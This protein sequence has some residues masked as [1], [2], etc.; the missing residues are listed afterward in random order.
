M[1]EQH[2]SKFTEIDVERINVV[3][4]DGT[5]R[6]VIANKD[7]SADPVLNGKVL[8]RRAGTYPGIIFFNDQGDECGG[9]LYGGKGE[10]GEHRACM[11][12]TF[13]QYKTDQVMGLILDDNEGRRNYGFNVWDR[14][15]LPL[16]EILE[17]IEAVNRMDD[18]PAK[19]QA[20]REL[21]P[22]YGVQR[23]FVGR[24][25]DGE[26]TVELYDRQGRPR[27]RMRIDADDI[28]RLEFLSDQGEVVYSL[29][30]RA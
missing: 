11:S 21:R 12:L 24:K 1:T 16:T 25:A 9:L 28:P 15:D 4:Q 3:D 22:F 20:R 14:P 13:D 19:E 30:P 23:I 6:M 10:L 26:A 17:R 29:P 7:R 27:I 18:G 5:V 2:R 8:G